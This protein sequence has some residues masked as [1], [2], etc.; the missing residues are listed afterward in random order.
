M[1]QLEPK[2][3]PGL[4]IPLVCTKRQSTRS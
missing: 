2:L 4:D 1:K 3:K